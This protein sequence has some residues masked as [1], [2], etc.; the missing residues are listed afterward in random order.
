MDKLSLFDI[1]FKND[2]RS[3]SGGVVHNGAFFSRQFSGSITKKLKRVLSTRPFRFIDSV[4]YLISHASTVAYGSSLLTFGAV[5]TLMYFLG[6]SA[7]GQLTTPIIGVILSIIAISL[8]FS[9][10][11][12]PLYLSDF[13]VTDYLFYE[14][15]CMKRHTTETAIKI[16]IL[17]S[18]FLGFGLAVASAFIPLW[19]IALVIGI[20]VCV[21]VGIESP[22]FVFLL[23]LFALPYVRFIPN[24]EIWLI[25]AVI[26]ALG[27]FLLKVFYGKR[28]I[29]VEQYDVF[30]G[31]MLL[32]LLISGIFIKG[33]ASFWGS[34]RMIALS[35]G[36]VLAGN[37]VANRRLAERSVNVIVV[38]GVFSV[39]ASILQIVMKLIRD[40]MVFGEDGL[41]F[42]LARKDGM[43]M[44]FIA[45]TLL[46][47][48]MIKQSS[49]ISARLY[50]VSS[51]ILII[52][53]ILSGEVFALLSTLLG[54]IAYHILKNNIRPGIFLP[55]LLAVPMLILLLP[56][57]FLDVI[58]TYS[59]SVVS[60]EKLIS[61]WN[62]SLKILSAN[63]LIGIG[64]G[65][66]SFAEEMAAI[67]VVGYPDSSNLFIELGLEA[68]IF[69]LI[70]FMCIILTR[71]KHRSIHYLYLRNS[72]IERLYCICGACMLS[73]LA[74]GMVNYIWSEPATYYFFW[75]LF[76]IGS[77]TLRV[78]KKD[79]DDKVIYYEESS[80]F[81]SS[82]IDIEIG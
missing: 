80:A 21:Y 24:G 3:K 16:P 67:G 74:F 30:L 48:V 81:D 44:F 23:S 2:E 14:I 53:L 69:A 38:S 35:V 73:F 45:A 42:I 41:S 26:F 55:L 52:G 22:E 82:V 6:L 36:Y 31:I 4:S 46:A 33:E 61:L 66:E 54:V 63:L 70:A 72:Q 78:A 17:L 40:G 39:I 76:G 65:T 1:L 37:I 5:S 50:T 15:F 7:D 20:A 12:L 79:Y 27:S 59:P 62:D 47:V 71:M 9:D 51:I 18:I 11:P 68:G 28:I 60:A 25:A 56:N 75:C 13:A 57:E 8:L 29:Y 10:K 32:C 43:A 19:Q 34:L 49:R 58:F 64:V 77:A